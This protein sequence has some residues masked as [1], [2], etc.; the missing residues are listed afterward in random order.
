MFD[1]ESQKL[2]ESDATPEN[3]DHWNFSS[4]KL[5]IL[6]VIPDD[7]DLGTEQS[8]KSRINEE[9]KPRKSKNWTQQ[10]E[11]YGRKSVRQRA[12]KIKVPITTSD[13]PSVEEDL[14][15]TPTEVELWKKAIRK[16]LS[17]LE[18]KKTWSLVKNIK[19][20]RNILTSQIVLKIKRNEL[21][22]RNILRIVS[23]QG[24]SNRSSKEN[25]AKYTF[26]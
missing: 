19:C 11:Y 24:G 21:V 1:D 7:S 15:A 6:Q 13:E 14:S 23:L 22:M 17:T 4:D 8:N 16:E 10:P 26:Q 9:S 20:A 5:D 18:K 25:M 2:T 3:E 12:N